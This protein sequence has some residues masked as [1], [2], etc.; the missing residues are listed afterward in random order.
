[1][2]YGEPGAYW[3]LLGPDI[4]LR[5]TDYDRERAAYR[6]RQSNWPGAEEFA[7]DQVLSVTSLDEAFAFFAERGGP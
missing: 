5:R 7:R 3:A 6:V 1:M 4:E 2:P